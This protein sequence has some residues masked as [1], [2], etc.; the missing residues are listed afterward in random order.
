[1]TSTTDTLQRQ[2]SSSLAVQLSRF[3]EL[4]IVAF[5]VVVIIV[6]VLLKPNFI[7]PI[8]IRSILLWI[9]LLSV[10][11]MGQMMVIITRGIDVSVGSILAFS[12]IVVGMIFRD[13]PE[14]NIYL[15]TL[16]GILLGAML[17]AING[18]LIAWL[19]VPPIITTLGT[20]SAYRGLVF[21]VS[22]GRQIDPNHVPTALI[23]WS[24]RGPFGIQ[25]IP[26]VV[27]I[28][29]VFTLHQDGTQYLRRRRQ[30]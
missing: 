28:A 15:G 5:L 6:T 10:V 3:R 24:Q 7:Q 22:G 27:I 2:R 8:N 19:K 23:R 26:W 13:F 21:I 1:M 20:L 14:F 25:W 29:I 17:G 16:L 30:S 4:G 12:G 9:P 18:G 11:A